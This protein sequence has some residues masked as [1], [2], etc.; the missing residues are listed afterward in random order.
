MNATTPALWVAAAILVAAFACI[1]ASAD[2]DSPPANCVPVH[3][4]NGV[5]VDWDCVPAGAATVP[6]PVNQTAPMGP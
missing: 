5:Q 3:Y 2:A 4:E 6:E 1:P